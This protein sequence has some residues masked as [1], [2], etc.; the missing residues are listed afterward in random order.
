MVRGITAVLLA[1]LDYQLSLPRA[2]AAEPISPV[3]AAICTNNPGARV[4]LITPTQFETLEPLLQA[5][6]FQCLTNPVAVGPVAGAAANPLPDITDAAPA[7][8]PVAEVPSDRGVVTNRFGQE[9]L[10]AMPDS[11][12]ERRGDPASPMSHPCGDAEGASGFM[13]DLIADLVAG[14]G[15][16]WL[17]GHLRNPSCLGFELLAGVADDRDVD[18]V[19]VARANLGVG[20]GSYGR[21]GLSLGSML[22]GL[23]PEDGLLEHHKR[24]I[25]IIGLETGIRF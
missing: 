22:V 15:I 21:F 12:A 18:I 14:A 20:I 23:D 17:F 13:G 19:S 4:Y 11:G 16:Q 8:L 1:A 10:P 3:A 5:H 9:P 25:P 2:F 6:G 7:G 24:F